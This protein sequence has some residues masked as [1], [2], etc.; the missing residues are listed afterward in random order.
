MIALELMSHVAIPFKWIE[1]LFHRECS[2]NVKSILEA[3]LIEGGKES[4]EG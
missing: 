1:S 4:Q 3:R 2:F